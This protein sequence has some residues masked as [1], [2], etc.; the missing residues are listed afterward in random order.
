M[1]D[2]VHVQV[3]I[4]VVSAV[5]GVVN[6]VV[7]R[8]VDGAGVVVAGKG[9]RGAE[10]LRKIAAVERRILQRF[11]VEGSGLR[12]AGGVERKSIGGHFDRGGLLCNAQL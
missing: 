3:Q 5:D 12:D 9:R 2:R 1:I 10:K 4:V 8:T 11:A 7:A 6:L